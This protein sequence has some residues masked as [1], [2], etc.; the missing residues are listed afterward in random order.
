MKGLKWVI[1]SATVL[2]LAMLCLVLLGGGCIKVQKVLTITVEGAGTTLPTP[3][4][5]NYEKD[6]FIQLQAIPDKY[7]AFSH[8]AGKDADSV[9]T[10]NKIFMFSDKSITAVFTVLNHPLNISNNPIGSGHVQ[11]DL[12]TDTGKAGFPHGQTARLTAIPN[13]AGT[14]FVKWSGDLGGPDNP[15]ELLITSE[16]NITAHFAKAMLEVTAEPEVIRAGQAFNVTMTVKAG[17]RPIPNIIINLT[18]N[19]GQPFQ[20]TKTAQTDANGVALFENLMFYEGNYNLMF[21]SNNLTSIKKD[22][23]VDVAGAGTTTD[24]YRLHNLYGLEFIREHMDACFRIAKDIDA[25]ATAAAS[26][27]GGKGWLPIGKPLVDIFKGQIDGNNKTISNLYINRPDEEYVGFIGFIQTAVQIQNLNLA[28]V[29]I[30]G[31]RRVGGLVGEIKDATTPLVENCSVTGVVKG[32]GFVGGMFGRLSGTVRNCHTDTAVEAI[33]VDGSSSN[34]GGLAGTAAEAAI[35][36][37]YAI[38]SV[39][40]DRRFGGL[41]GNA[42]NTTISQCYALGDMKRVRLS[43]GGNSIGGFIGELA[44][45]CHVTDCYGRGD[46]DGRQDLGGFCGYL[47][48]STIERCY[49]TGLIPEQA[50]LTNRGGF[51]GYRLNLVDAVITDC[52]YDS[53][54]SGCSDTGNGEPLTTAKM[55][56]A[57]NYG[58]WNFGTVW[59]I[60]PAINDGYPYLR[61]TPQ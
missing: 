58:G 5:H 41:L 4:Q 6:A 12:V 13:S 34:L 60:S 25:S 57:D 10:D 14:Y 27:N 31:Y 24:P 40:G 56:N 30:T 2:L 22:F 8:W 38:G 50:T 29:N 59:D 33:L 26:Y 3:G 47:V 16:K 54:T 36:N 19:K 28:D 7:S 52:Y 1:G 20:G 32:N 37:C 44:Y 42:Y 55:H 35:A 45:G 15:V 48:K 46:V 17:E 43:T 23:T 49:S 18:E 21:S 53:E 51:V 61:N 9:T 11:V 39:T